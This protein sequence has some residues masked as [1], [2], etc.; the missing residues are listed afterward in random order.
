MVRIATLQGF[1][2]AGNV[3]VC[4]WAGTSSSL[5]LSARDVLFASCTSIGW[6]KEADSFLDTLWDRIWTLQYWL[7]VL[8]IFLLSLQRL[9]NLG[10]VRHRRSL[11]D[12][13]SV[14]LAQ[15]VRLWFWLA[16]HVRDSLTR[17]FRK[18]NRPLLR[19]V[20]R[21]AWSLIDLG[22][23]LDLRWISFHSILNF[24]LSVIK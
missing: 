14:L 6:A 20:K 22:R 10:Q 2:R 21:N 17:N 15:Y 5:L 13:A 24:K 1:F 11:S 12:D 18:S 19:Q 9:L 7:M 16:P 8:S 23:T 3:L 4:V